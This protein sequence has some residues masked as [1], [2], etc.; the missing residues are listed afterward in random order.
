[1]PIT[2]MAQARTWLVHMRDG[3][4]IPGFRIQWKR[5]RG[6]MCAVDAVPDDRR[7]QTTPAV[8]D[9]IGCGLRRTVALAAIAHD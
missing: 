7:Q 4:A 6:A 8:H 5:K 1:M 2:P 9:A 3:F